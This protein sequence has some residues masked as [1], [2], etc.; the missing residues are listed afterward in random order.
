[1]AN[2][3]NRIII[4]W[5]GAILFGIVA[6]MMVIGG[7]EEAGGACCWII[8]FV[9]IAISGQQA[10]EDA[11]KTNILYIPQVPIQQVAQ[12]NIVYIPQV[13]AQQVVQPNVSQQASNV[14]PNSPPVAVA[15]PA[16]A[17]PDKY[18]DTSEGW[19]GKARNLELARDWDGAAKAY[20]KAG[21]YAEAGR[22]RQAHMEKEDSQVK[23][24]IDRIGHNIQDSVVMGDS[25]ADTD[26]K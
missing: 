22:I 2:G 5:G 4:G 20:Q 9:A 6:L 18:P 17:E 10:K 1:M 21:L 12:P 11:N 26:P 23:I 16:P 13:P 3:A 8:I 7:A 24:N 14:F 15:K 19:A 25:D